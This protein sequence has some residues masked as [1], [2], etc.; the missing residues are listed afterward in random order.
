MKFVLIETSLNIKKV[1]TNYKIRRF[2]HDSIVK[3]RYVRS[4]NY[5]IR[6]E[7]FTSKVRRL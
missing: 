4:C 5:S 6:R 1:K 7:E 2:G 3:V